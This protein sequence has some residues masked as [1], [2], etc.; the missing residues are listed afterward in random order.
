MVISL[1][2]LK[3]WIAFWI[4]RNLAGGRMPFYE[5]QKL[6]KHKTYIA[7]IKKSRLRLWVWNSAVDYLVKQKE[8]TFTPTLKEKF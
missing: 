7:P 1:A 2:P 5:S 3:I 4:W 8:L 6:L